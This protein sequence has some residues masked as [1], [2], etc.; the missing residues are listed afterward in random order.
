M[1]RTNNGELEL[2][3]VN[4]IYKIVR[5]PIKDGRGR[6]VKDD[7]NRIVKEEVPVFVKDLLVPHSF[8]AEG[9]SAYGK[10][11][12]R[13][14]EIAKKRSVIYDKYSARYYTVAHSKEEIEDALK[15]AYDRP[16]VGFLAHLLKN[17]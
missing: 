1:I 16:P 9:V 14:N 8:L 2:K 6:Y 17:K 3:I 5:K 15:Q 11:M 10:T 12:T 4:P 13:K 7:L